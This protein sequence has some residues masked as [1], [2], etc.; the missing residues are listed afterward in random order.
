MASQALFR[1]DAGS[2][3]GL[4]A[5]FGFDY[6]P[7][8]VSLENVQITAGARINAPFEVRPHDWIGIGFVYSKISDPFSNFGAIL[9]GPRLGSEKVFELNYALK[10]TPYWLVEPTFQYYADIGGNS[11]LSN[12]PTLGF[13]T[14]IN[15]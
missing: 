10:I 6:T 15:F 12:A 9:G 3:R 8:D 13:R 4:D 5:T 11:H 7:G 2:N 14:K 1:T